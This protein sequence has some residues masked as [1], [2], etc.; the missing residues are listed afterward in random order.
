M[1]AGESALE[2]IR[3]TNPDL[4]M[5]AEAVLGALTW[6][7]GV[8]VITLEGVQQFLWYTLPRKFLVDSGTHHEIA[9]AAAVL[10]ERL[11]LH[12]YAGIATS[13]MTREVLDAYARSDAEGVAAFRRAQEASGI[14]PPDL[15]DF[16]WGSVMGVEESRAMSAVARALE[17]AIDAGA[18]TP[19]SRGWRTVQRRVAA[20][21]LGADHP[22]IP[23][24]SWRT[25]I[26]TERLEEWTS[27][28]NVELA[29]LRKRVANRLLHPI[30]VDP[31]EA[32][33]SLE[34][35]IWLLR[36]IGDAVQATQGGNLSREFVRSATEQ[37]NWWDDMPGRPN[38]EEDVPQLNAL[39]A[40]SRRTKA[41]RRSRRTIAL[42]KR[43]H[44]IAADPLLAR[45]AVIE[46]MTQDDFPRHALATVFL[47][48]LDA[49]V[50]MPSDELYRRAAE[51]LTESG[52]RAGGE[53]LDPRTLAGSLWLERQWL[54]LLGMLCV[55][56]PWDAR[57]IELSKT[58]ETFAL[59]VLRH[60]ATGPRHT[61]R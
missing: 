52:W 26:L 41:V 3:A 6:G 50:P 38:R 48:L 31:D 54:T 24:Q 58:G 43:G 55:E 37:R 20:E 4:A 29:R 8:D 28:R 34:P 49:D 35:F 7:E 57:L 53:P 39:H 11:G 17:V 27:T 51:L 18:F 59:T 15:D 14:E 47:L 23:G 12:R 2:D 1:D 19:G 13:D 44:Q 61:L 36:E 46:A 21:A 30:D 60:V 10:L 56:G 9:R 25:A 40:L 16:A 5:D 33:A 22:V 32:A 42:T 45:H